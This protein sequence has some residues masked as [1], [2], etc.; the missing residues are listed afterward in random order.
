M[1]FSPAKCRPHG[2]PGTASHG[3]PRQWAERRVGE[4]AVGGPRQLGW[5]VLGAK[6]APGG[7]SGPTPKDLVVGRSG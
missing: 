7:A 2:S 5:K 3:L 6:G 1:D 4:A